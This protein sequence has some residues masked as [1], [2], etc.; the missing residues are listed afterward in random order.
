MVASPTPIR[1][2][3]CCTSGWRVMIATTSS[4]TFSV[5]F[6]VDPGT[7]STRTALKSVLIDGWNVCGKVAKAAIVATNASTPTPIIFQRC[8]SVQRRIAI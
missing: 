1:S 5:C 6:N 8:A 4:V 7:S 2:K 3:A